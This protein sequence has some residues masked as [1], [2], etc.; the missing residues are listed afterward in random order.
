V[1]G[2]SPCSH[3]APWPLIVVGIALHP[4]PS[5]A[6]LLS[7]TC[8]WLGT[9]DICVFPLVDASSKHTSP[10][11]PHGERRVP[12]HLSETESQEIGGRTASCEEC[13]DSSLAM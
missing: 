12:I 1:I 7:I 6:P 5:S 11:H 10:S 8:P 4:P 9:V 2:P 13:G 3:F